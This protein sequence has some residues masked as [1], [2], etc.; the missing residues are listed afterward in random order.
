[1][2]N[3]QDIN[4]F[5]NG[6]DPLERIIKVECDN[7]S[8][9]AY[10][11]Y[12]DINGDKKCI[13]D[14]FY[15][16]C[17][18][19]SSTEHILFNGEKNKLYGEILNHNIERVELKTSDDNGNI[20]ERLA[21]G[22]CIMYRAIQPMSFN[23][24]SSFFEK[25]GA[26]LYPSKDDEAN[27]GSYFMVLPLAEQH[28]VSTGKRLFKGYADY[29]DLTRMSW[30]LRTN[31]EDGMISCIG[32]RTNKGLEQVIEV[33]G[34]DYNEKFT[35]ELNA[36]LIFFNT[37]KY[38]VPDVLTGY[39]TEEK[40][41]NL[42]SDRIKDHG[43]TLEKL[44]SKIFKHPIYKSQ[45][46]SMLMLGEDNEFYNPT[47]LWGIN[48][49]D[50][51]HAVKR[52]MVDDKNI[53]K[54]DID[55]VSSYTKVRKK[56]K[57]VVKHN[58][59]DRL[60]NSKSLSN[61]YCKD[62]GLWTTM[63]GKSKIN[64][65][66]SLVSGRFLAK[67]SIL[68]ELYEIDR[69][70]LEYNRSNFLTGQ[71]LPVPFEKSCT[72]GTGSMWKSVMTAWSYENYI[73]IPIP[74]KQR[75]IIG[76]LS[77]LFKVGFVNNVVKIDYNAF[78]PSIALS[79]NITLPTDIS[80]VMPVLLEHMLSER[81]RYKKLRNENRDN[82]E[83]IKKNILS[84]RK[85]GDQSLLSKYKDE[86]NK[87]YSLSKKYD[88]LQAPFKKFIVSWFGSISS[89]YFPWNEYD[90]GEE[91]TCIGRQMFRLLIAHFE[92]KL[93][94][95]TVVGDSVVGDTEL[96]VRDKVKGRVERMKIKDM[97]DETK[98]SI[99]C[100]GREY[101]YSDKPYKVLCRSGWVDPAYIY[102][103][104]TDKP[105]YRITDGNVVVECTEDHSLF[106]RD[107]EKILPSEI[108]ENT[109]LEFI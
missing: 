98:A 89:P 22:Y 51:K 32:V 30:T 60:Y 95:K 17:W 11:V 54:D 29:D 3:Q 73:A 42:L 83:L 104:K 24:F 80:N 28:L 90:K 39:G 33:D 97:F 50:A 107:K 70:E 18:A 36:I 45:R 96:F 44:S 61:L 106:N 69:I 48:I 21:N 34:K 79:N 74:E 16:F 4:T 12:K 84:A 35:S 6:H 55:Y 65:E 64:G 91:I 109:K 81:E 38:I 8:D 57:C 13:K 23:E 9:T 77:R 31:H 40:L 93:G 46:R 87:Y 15:P 25:A 1:M 86:W 10:V 56:N 75:Q 103:H 41:W 5:L 63:D 72:M 43:T 47:I 78:Y 100:L 101:D 76:G 88:R 26:K 62:T 105:I 53:R 68:D 71:L 102:R 94:Y 58:M 67:Q 66:S 19:K 92:K 14:A 108:D 27:N 7:W 52:G 49:T 20:N 2:S 99:D 59:F 85:T 37:I 82:A